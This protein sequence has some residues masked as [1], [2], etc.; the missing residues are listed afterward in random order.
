MAAVVGIGALAYLRYPP[1]GTFH[2][3]SHMDGKSPWIFPFLPSER[4]SQP[5]AQ[6]DGWSGQRLTGDPVYASVRVPGPYESAD[7]SIEY[8]V[9][10]QPLL[11]FGTSQQADGSSAT[12]I[13]MYS[14]ELNHTDWHA[15]TT[16]QQKGYVR[17]GTSDDRL[18]STIPT[19]LAVWNATGTMPLMFDPA[20]DATTTQVS[21]R[22]SHDFYFVPSGGKISA[23]FV[24]QI[25]NRK[26]GND[27]VSFR[28]Y[29]GD[30]EIGDKAYTLRLSNETQMGAPLTRDITLDDAT[31]GV[32]RISI[33]APDDV[34]I[35]EVK[36]TSKHWVV[37]PRLYAG[38][39]VGYLKDQ[40]PVN[41]WTN[42]RHLVAETFHKEGLQ[43]ITFGPKTGPLQRTHATLRLDRTDD[44]PVVALNAPKGDI[45]YVLDGY[46]A[47]QKDAF[48]EPKP[49]RFTD[50]T[51]V[52]PEHLDAVLTTYVPPVQLPDGW[53]KSTFHLPLQPNAD[54]LRVTISA[55]GLMERAGSVDIRQMQ[56]TYQRQAGSLK[57]WAMTL[58]Q[59]LANAWHRL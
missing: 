6:P 12:M 34:F 33:F 40:L 27:V 17:N 13:P 5:G 39:T 15:V 22:G 35:R 53:L 54:V 46:V 8:R 58:R 23:S 38:D 2:V 18:L 26:E 36:T 25:A 45:R 30:Q 19:D 28:V 37:G 1:S 20:F 51:L 31:P 7:V 3:T 41:V 49:R 43:T 47:F 16:G 9:D 10:R 11:E 44:A 42:S 48:F 57:D 32:Y 21:L 24:Y 4:V 14:A 52:D 50:A 55:P 59:E 29:R 56:I